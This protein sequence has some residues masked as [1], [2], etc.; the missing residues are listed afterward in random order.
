MD[1]I[2]RCT[3]VELDHMGDDERIVQAARVSTGRDLLK[4]APKGTEG[5]INYLMRKRHG[6]PFEHNAFTF[7]DDAPLNVWLEHVRHRIG[8]SYNQKSGR[9]GEYEPRFFMPRIRTQTGKP[10]EY[11]MR[12]VTGYKAIRA[13]IQLHVSYRVSWFAYQ[14]LLKQGV[15]REVARF[16]LPGSLMS[17]GYV[18]M[19]ARSMMHFISL[20]TDRPEAMFP[21]KPMEEIQQ[22]AEAYERV[23]AARFPITYAAF[24]NHGR[25]AP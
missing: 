8:I 2:T 6:S 9:Y 20:R 3:V 12:P 1:F 7:W 22:V 25:V 16:V 4:Q 17:Q 19:N 24:N 23:L 10:G 14:R 13:G 18:T 5:L 11:I 15:A 21:S